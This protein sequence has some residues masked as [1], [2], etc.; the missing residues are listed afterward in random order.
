MFAR[1]TSEKWAFS[2]VDLALYYVRRIAHALA[3]EQR[4]R[5]LA[6][7][8]FVH[9][10][11]YFGTFFTLNYKYIHN[12]VY[13]GGTSRHKKQGKSSAKRMVF[14]ILRCLRICT[15]TGHVIGERGT[16]E[17]TGKNRTAH[18]IRD[19]NAEI[20]ILNV[21]SEYSFFRHHS[22]GHAFVCRIKF[23]VKFSMYNAFIRFFWAEET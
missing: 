1:P 18:G 9:V 17:S 16:N 13:F 21:A 2:H 22:L 4:N 20:I 15:R 23:C 11:L 14:I 12:T 19:D 8:A 3:S 5:H 7:F 6:V 10:I